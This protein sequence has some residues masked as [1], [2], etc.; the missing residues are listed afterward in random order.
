MLPLSKVF[1]YKETSYWCQPQKYSSIGFGVQGFIF[2]GWSGVSE[3]FMLVPRLS[4]FLGEIYA[5][6]A[7][8][9]NEKTT[10]WK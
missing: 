9:W 3:V 5:F 7:R 1:F 8:S 2:C 10:I 4:G 6:G